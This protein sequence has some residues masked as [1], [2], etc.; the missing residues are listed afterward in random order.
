MPHILA[1]LK[2]VKTADIGRML[3]TDASK[4]QEEGLYLEHWWLNADDTNEVFFLFK[5]RDLRHAKKFITQIHSEAL[6]ENPKAVL[7]QMTFLE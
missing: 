3:K 6:K 2:G 5:T 7:P 1:K 4:H